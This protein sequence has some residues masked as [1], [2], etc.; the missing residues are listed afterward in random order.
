MP[1]WPV[2]QIAI[3]LSCC[4]KHN[5]HFFVAGT[6]HGML[7]QASCFC[8]T[9]LSFSQSAFHSLSNVLFRKDKIPKNCRQQVIKIIK[10]IIKVL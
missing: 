6:R 4:C 2:G 9:Q 3:E 8:R 5:K 7:S 1:V 10:I